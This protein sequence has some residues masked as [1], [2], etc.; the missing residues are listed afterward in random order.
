MLRHGPPRERTMQQRLI[1]LAA[2][3]VG[4]VITLEIFG[5]NRQPDATDAPRQLTHEQ[6]LA[7]IRD[8]HAWRLARKTRPMWA[9]LIEADEVGKEFQTADHVAE[10]ARE[11]YWLS[12]GVAGEP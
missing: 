5:M 6:A 8:H 9:R 10:R 7:W 4:L 2:W 1:V 12:V 3:L 11:G